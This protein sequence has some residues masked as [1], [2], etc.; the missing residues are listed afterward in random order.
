MVYSILL[1]FFVSINSIRFSDVVTDNDLS[2]YNII[3]REILKGKVL[4]KDI[5]DHKTP[6]IF[7]IHT[8][9]AL[10][11]NHHIGLFI[12]EVLLL[13]ITLI[14]TFK[15]C[16]LYL[17]SFKSFISCLF[18]SCFLCYIPITFGYSRTEEY[19]I[20]FMMVAL[21]I[22]AKYFFNEEKDVT[23]T[24]DND[25]YMA[26]IGIM[27]AMCFMT[28]I[29]A[30]IL[31]VPF[32][33]ALFI[34]LLKEK[35]YKRILRLLIFGVLGVILTILPYLIYMVATNSVDD[36]IYA[37]V[38]T[39][40][41]YAKSNMHNKL[42]VFDIAIKMLTEYYVFYILIAV[43]LISIVV[44]NINKYFKYSIISSYIIGIVYITFSQRVHCYYLVIL[45]P[46]YISICFLIFKKYDKLLNIKSIKS[47]HYMIIMVVVIA[48]NIFLNRS[49]DVQV[50]NQVHRAERINNVIDKNFEDKKNVK[51]LSIGF[52]PEVYTYTKLDCPYKYWFI[53]TLSY[54][55]D[56]TIFMSQYQY[57]LNG[58]ND[59]VI[60]R[61][62]EHIYEYPTSI[63][64]Q[65]LLILS[66]DYDLAD[67]IRTNEFVG[68]IK[69]YVKKQ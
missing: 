44:L 47:F 61:E 59:I 24:R 30:T 45:F 10:L 37:V 50:I 31:F 66:S 34:K 54:K 60:M 9:A 4:Y 23:T 46:Y 16:N 7:F 41:N 53:P 5:F 62:S 52:F 67:T 17:D 35:K 21:Y 22:F 18:L 25:I 13:A 43:S 28:N 65:I 3:G 69:I 68:N 26:V 42:S 63:R 15:F 38:T 39:N 11:P 51:L 40:L 36:A 2:I 20:T 6:Y 49:I 32:A 48:L 14:F 58:D 29:R 57:L 19:A 1:K 12:L 27:A 33:V 56:N 64:E 8:L 55:A